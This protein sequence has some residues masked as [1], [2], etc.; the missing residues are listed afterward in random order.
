MS[1]HMKSEPIKRCVALGVL[2]CT[3]LSILGGCV[4]RAPRETLRIVTEQSTWDRMNGQLYV[5]EKQYEQAHTDVDIRVEYLPTEEP[6]R[7]VYLQKLRT[8]MLRGGG[9]DCYLLPT[10]STLILDSPAQYTYVQVE[11][12]FADVELAM[13]N[14]L[15]YD[16]TEFYEADL[17]L[18]KDVLNAR[19][20]EAGTVENAR[21]VLPLRYDIPV[22]Y[23]RNDALKAAGLDP[24]I[25]YSDIGTVME[26]VAGTGDPVLA[27]GLLGGVSSV[28]S[29]LIDYRRGEVTLDADTLAR[30]MSAYQ[31]LK[32]LLGDRYFHYDRADGLRHADLPI[33]GDAVILEKL[34][35]KSYVYCEYGEKYDP[36]GN[37][38]SKSVVEYY[39]LCVGSIQDAF[40]YV[41]MSKYENIDLTVAPMRTPN[42]ELVATVTYYGALGAGCKNPALAYDFLRQFLQEDSQWERNRPERNHTVPLKDVADNT[43]NDLQYPGLIE[44]GWP[45]QDVGALPVLWQARR[46][47]IYI[48]V[49]GSSTS[50]EAKDRMRRIGLMGVL[51]DERIP[52][53]DLTIDRVCFRGM[54]ADRLDGMLGQLNDPADANAPTDVDVRELAEQFIRELRRHLSEG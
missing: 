29:D 27:G 44:A 7:S 15:F 31:S 26:A 18:N 28:L 13:R 53:F 49:M 40:A 35:I 24:A 12:L 5:L 37:P 47:Q 23:A 50:A 36:W 30:Y 25:L 14:G 3:L 2:L 21:Y 10:D 9:P 45:V 11:P 4:G 20:M 22:I 46:L 17:A 43:S 8:D 48:R 19:V 33:E 39:P 54:G 16:I 1:K 38:S 41:P 51:E 6:E 32:A 34:D 42:G 52:L